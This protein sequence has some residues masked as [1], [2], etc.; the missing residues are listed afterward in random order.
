VN[1]KINFNF[2]I[3]RNLIFIPNHA[4][5]E[6]FFSNDEPVIEL[7]TEVSSVEFVTKPVQIAM[8][9]MFADQIVSLQVFLWLQKF[10]V[11]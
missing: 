1:L 7:L 4:S 8:Y 3:I 11:E 6:K 2:I 9:I 10:V 5:K